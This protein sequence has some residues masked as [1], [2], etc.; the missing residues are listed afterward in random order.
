MSAQ[1]PSQGGI[2]PRLSG[3]PPLRK[4]G[5][6]GEGPAACDATEDRPRASQA[7]RPDPRAWCRIVAAPTRAGGTRL[8]AC[9]WPWLPVTRRGETVIEP[10][11][12]PAPESAARA[13]HARAPT[14]PRELAGNRGRGGPRDGRAQV[15]DHVLDLGGRHAHPGP[16]PGRGPGAWMLRG[17]EQ[18]ACLGFALFGIVYLVLVN[19]GW[20]GAQFGH[21]LTAG[22]GRSR[23]FPGPEAGR[24]HSRQRDRRSSLRTV[25]SSWRRGRSASGIS[26]RSA[27]WRW[28]CSSAWSAVPWRCTSHGVPAPTVA[29]DLESLSIAWETSRV[30]RR[31]TL[32]LASRMSAPDLG[33]MACQRL[34]ARVGQRVEQEQRGVAAS[35]VRE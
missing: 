12:D 19:W 11:N 21:D 26:S 34:E 33:P 25:P 35:E 31:G 9:G 23:R 15:V 5:W 3:F 14:D 6:G 29:R 10:A 28:P 27:G 2:R 32:L 13:V 24:G 16:L 8:G 17:E 7:P 1:S 22:L 18:A 30:Q 4:G 20:V